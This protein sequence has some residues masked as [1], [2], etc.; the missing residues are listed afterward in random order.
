MT[1][2]LVCIANN[3][4]PSTTTCKLKKTHKSVS[5]TVAQAIFNILPLKLRPMVV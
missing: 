2:T 1:L 5:S 3:V 4:R